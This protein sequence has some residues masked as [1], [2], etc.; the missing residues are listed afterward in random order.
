[1]RYFK[2]ITSNKEG[3]FTIAEDEFEKL[4]TAVQKGVPAVFREGVLLNANM[5]VSVVLD[6][7]R[8]RDVLELET[9]G[10]KYEQPS[11]FAK[12]LGKKMLKLKG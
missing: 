5:C 3:S 4:M 7:D 9:V 1:M 11:E 10:Q 8:N 6:K 2:L 12:I